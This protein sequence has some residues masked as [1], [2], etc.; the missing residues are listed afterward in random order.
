MP[1]CR[2]VA[3]LFSVSGRTRH[4]LIVNG[5]SPANTLPTP[6]SRAKQDCPDPPKVSPQPKEIILPW[7]PI[8][9]GLRVKMPGQNAELKSGSC[10]GAGP[11]AGPT[12]LPCLNPHGESVICKIFRLRRA[13]VEGSGASP[14]AASQPLAEVSRAGKTGVDRAEKVS[15]R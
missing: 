2:L 1:A 6:L 8:L 3:G 9:R 5:P 11:R 10:G 14:S 7:N 4:A 12:E 13:R 15:P